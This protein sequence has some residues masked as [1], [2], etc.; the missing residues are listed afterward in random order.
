MQNPLNRTKADTLP[1]RQTQLAVAILGGA[2]EL[3]AAQ[4]IGVTTRTARRYLR[5]PLVRQAIADA[6]DAAFAQVTRRA[7]AAMG[8]ALATLAS[9]MADPDAPTSSR[10]AAAR[11]I[12][13]TAVKL[14]ETYNLAERVSA[15]EAQAWAER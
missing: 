1:P 10:V 6:Q 15:L 4:A 12:L 14:T 5:N 8:A 11:V 2:T 9:I 13:E 7:V 3:Q